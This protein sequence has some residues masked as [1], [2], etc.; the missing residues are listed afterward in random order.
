MNISNKIITQQ[1]YIINNYKMFKNI[2]RSN[3]NK[4]KWG[5]WWNYWKNRLIFLKCL[6]LLILKNLMNTPR[7]WRVLML[8]YNTQLL[9][10]WTFSIVWYSRNIKDTTF[11]K[12]DLFPSS[13]GGGG[14]ETPTPLGPLKRAN[15]N[16]WTT[17][18]RFTQL[19]YHLWTGKFGGR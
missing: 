4:H 16:H 10:F 2:S 13:G 11:P 14:G 12:L 5:S 17:P 8:V 1:S 15:L 3:T 19:Y 7:F 18:V 6:M 9:G